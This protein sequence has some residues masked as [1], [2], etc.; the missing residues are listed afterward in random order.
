MSDRNPGY[1]RKDKNLIAGCLEI[2]AS[3]LS[4]VDRVAKAFVLVTDALIRETENEIELA[5]AMGDQG[6]LVKD[7]IKRNVIEFVQGIFNDAYWR[8]IGRKVEDV[9]EQS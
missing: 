1:K 6:N 8:V 4:E 3:D 5:R 7:Q 2:M 9:R